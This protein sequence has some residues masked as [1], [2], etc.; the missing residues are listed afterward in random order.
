MNKNLEKTGNY[1]TI[2]GG[3]LMLIIIFKEISQIKFNSADKIISSSIS[4]IFLIPFIVMI[5]GLIIIK[6]E[7][8]SVLIKNNMT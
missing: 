6:Y 7:E 3:I 8:H 1:L 2:S 4:G 5:F